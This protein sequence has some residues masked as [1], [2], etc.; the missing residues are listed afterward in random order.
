M[1]ARLVL[2]CGES[3]CAVYVGDSIGKRAAFDVEVLSQILLPERA[4]CQIAYVSAP[5]ARVKCSRRT[6]RMVI[7]LDAIIVHQ[8]AMEFSPSN[9]LTRLTVRITC[10]FAT[11]VSNYGLQFH[12]PF[13]IFAIGPTNA[14]LAA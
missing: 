12:V 7:F 4:V 1:S 13:V 10:M 8:Q 6:T 3:L 14:M 11:F 9:A 2:Q 5:L